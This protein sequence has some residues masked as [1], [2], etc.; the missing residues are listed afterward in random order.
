MSRRLAALCLSLLFATPAVALPAG[1]GF[2]GRALRSDAV[3]RDARAALA[4]GQIP[5]LGLAIVD[6]GKV[7]FLG[8]YGYRD[9]A[10]RLPLQ[11]DTVMYAASLTKSAFAYLV[12]ELADE[13]VIDLDAPISRYLKKPLPDYEPYKDLA[14]DDRWR[15]LTPRLLMGHAS[16]FANF[17]FLEP[18]QKLRF[19]FEPGAR[20]AYSGEGINLMQFVLEEGLGLDVEAEMKRRMYVPFGMTR[21]SMKWRDDF[22]GNLTTGYDAAGKAEG[23][24]MRSRVRAAGNMDTT[25]SDY[26]RFLAALTRGEGLG[27]TG[28]ARIRRRAVSISS[29]HQFPTLGEPDTDRYAKIRLASA[30]GWV[31]YDTRFG[32]ALTKGGHDDFTDNLAICI[33]RRC[34][35]MMTNSG[36]G[37]RMF[38]ALVRQIMGD[39]GVPWDWE[40]NP[41]LP[42]QPSS[43]A[44]SR[45]SAD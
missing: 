32:Q 15:K 25:I 3:E 40:Y 12:A 45:P 20:Y 10:K 19:H 2:D 16:G 31:T 44:P 9:V 42:L 30:L 33:A 18:D 1:H 4:K 8:T 37:A 6:D 5:S 28:Q 29:P 24:H 38:P 11:P 36:V 26:A 23:H 13:G 41:V 27:P 14:G 34:I 7:S 22:A 39:P 43:P 35:L 21:T 17:A